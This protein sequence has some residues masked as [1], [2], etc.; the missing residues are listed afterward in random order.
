MATH[1]ARW[2]LNPPNPTSPRLNDET[3]NSASLMPEHR[4]TRYLASRT[5]LA[6]MMFMLYGTQRLPRIITST[7]GRPHFAD[8]ELP[9]F[10]IAYAGNMVGVLLATEGRCG[11]DM[12]LRRSFLAPSPAMPYPQ[13]SS[14]ETTWIDNQNDP[15]EARTQLHTLRQSVLKLTDYPQIS[16]SALQ[17][18]P[19]SGRLRV[20]NEPH[21]EAISDAE[22]IL[23]WG[24]TVAPG[25]ER[26]KLWEFDGQQGWQALPDAEARSRSAQ[27][28]LIRLTG[29]PS[30][31]AAPHNTFSRT[32]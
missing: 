18:L 8:D 12:E 30:E 17:L 22:D 14:S 23:I 11:L 1:F 27:G 29:I 16:A 10:S 4:R 31:S 7:A 6:E 26:L 19:G 3:L 20:T 24:C 15:Y 9:D 5:L 2:A 25:V 28:S 32:S 13:T 21:I